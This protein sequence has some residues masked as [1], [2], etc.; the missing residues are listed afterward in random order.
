MGV[1]GN[2]RLT[3]SAN[4]THFLSKKNVTG[5]FMKLRVASF[6]NIYGIN[7]VQANPDAAVLDVRAAAVIQKIF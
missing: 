4:K 2:V 6:A 3:A 7:N 1:G 5:T